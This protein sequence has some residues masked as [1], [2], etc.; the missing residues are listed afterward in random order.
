LVPGGISKTG[1]RSSWIFE[2]E[3]IRSRRERTSLFSRVLIVGETLTV[4]TQD[5]CKITSP[6]FL[7]YSTPNT[8]AGLGVAYKDLSKHGT[9]IKCLR[10]S[11]FEGAARNH[12]NDSSFAKD[13][14][15]GCEARIQGIRVIMRHV[16]A[17]CWG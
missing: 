2:S 15:K 3:E 1:G 7:G 6:S 5:H 9:R 12:L 8:S 16:A 17:T 13:L 14:N 11:L 10:I 4:Q